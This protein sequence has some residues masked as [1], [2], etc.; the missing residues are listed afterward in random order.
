[1]HHKYLAV[2][3]I[4]FL[5]INLLACGGGG[6]GGSGKGEP[7][8]LSITPEQASP[9][10]VV[11]VV[12]E[13]FDPTTD[14]I[15]FSD[16]PVAVSSLV[17]LSGNAAMGSGA[18]DSKTEASQV[19][20]Q[21]TVPNLSKGYA[22]VRI[23]RDNQAHGSQYFYVNEAGAAA[24]PS[25]PKDPKIPAKNDDAKATACIINYECTKTL[26]SQYVCEN[27]VCVKKAAS[28]DD[29]S[30]D[31]DEDSDDNDD[32]D[33]GDGD[34]G[35]A[36]SKVTVTHKLAKENPGTLDLVEFAFDLENVQAA[37]IK[38]PLDWN[39]SIGNADPIPV[40]RNNVD[41]FKGNDDY[42]FKP[43]TENIAD[44]FFDGATEI[45]EWFKADGDPAASA[46]NVLPYNYCWIPSKNTNQDLKSE[47]HEARSMCHVTL[48]G[49][50]WSY[51][52]IFI[53][54][55][56]GK[57][58]GKWDLWL[59]ENTSIFQLYY[60]DWENTQRVETFK[61]EY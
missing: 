48:S 38:A 31:D 14:M 45:L 22:V 2:F 34:E 40:D 47:Y 42:P 43:S 8:V 30:G 3:F 55:K 53:P 37:F 58:K 49:Y 18:T 46:E 7:Q 21:V 24:L 44:Y 61:V 6:D 36:E 19:V 32:G 12:M 33:A 1:M 29:D 11:E 5:A 60:L 57:A 54:L 9:G 23:W 56:D 26:G 28:A 52:Q 27:K 51:V 20:A 10:D 4:G 15:A 25:I 35:V 41:Q 13:N 50:G 16:V 39:D 17:S 59:P